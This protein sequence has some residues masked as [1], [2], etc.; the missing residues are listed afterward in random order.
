MNG[1]LK[2]DTKTKKFNKYK[3]PNNNTS[4]N[5]SNRLN[6]VSSNSNK[7]IHNF[8]LNNIHDFYNLYE[9]IEI[10]DQKTEFRYFCFRYLNYI[11]NLDLCEIKLN[12]PKEAVLIEFRKFPHI[13]FLLRNMIHKLNEE[14]SHTIICGNLNYDFVKN[15]CN[16]ISPNIKIIKLDK[17]NMT[18]FE[19]SMYLTT[20]GF[21]NNFVGEKI[22]IY[23]EDSCIFKRNINDFL[24]WDYIGAPWS[25]QQND[26]PNCVGNG[27]F[28]LRTKQCM[29]DVINTISVEDTVLNSSTLKYMNNVNLRK[30]PEDVYFSL[31]MQRYNIGKVADW[32][33]A[34]LFSSESIVNANSL[35]GHCFW[36]NDPI[37]KERMYN[38]VVIQFKPYYNVSILEHRGGWKTV[39]EELAKNDFF[40][41]NSNYDFFDL[42]EKP[43]LWE[44]NFYCH[45]KWA[46][47]IHC[48]QKT[49]EYLNII[50]INYLF[51][52]Q[53]FIKSLKNCLYII[54]LSKYVADFLKDMFKMYKINGIKIIV[55]PHPINSNNIP[56]FDIH[57]F[58]NNNDKHIIQIG[59][60]L[61]K[62]S[63][64]YKLEIEGKYKKLWLTGT[65][66]FNKLKIL[67]NMEIK[68]Y[69]LK[70]VSLKNVVMKYT[71]TIE[72]YDEL[73][74]KN[75]VFVD[76]F[77]AS[78]NNT[79][80]ECIVRGTPIIINN[81]GGVSEYLGKDY[82]LYF[83]KLENVNDMLS[84]DK[85]FSAYFYLKNVKTLSISDFCKK[86]I[87]IRF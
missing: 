36:L 40:N 11:R 66:N 54:S 12:Q 87:N 19:Y 51:K 55:I 28:S 3:P 71:N 47:I 57:K 80:L 13:E 37:W 1:S 74:T 41:E 26:T 4:I 79:V 62:I 14:W 85:I 17:D 82:P 81:I 42:I 8:Y 59:Q 34:S 48:T 24:N 16:S 60:Q 30:A 72:E 86:I 33:N 20:L 2:F 38:N 35:G 76:L 9:I 75:I 53:N 7:S 31:N 67:L 44:T 22:L 61:R 32:D 29:I 70:N 6:I 65:T 77:D 46:G 52:N 68:T 83:E 15:I 39:I 63:S 10:K 73:L 25:K 27:G 5:L 23:Q 49:P 84:Y 78:A 21:W 45:N 43:F 64:I 18:Q 50:N 58:I 56:S 69:N